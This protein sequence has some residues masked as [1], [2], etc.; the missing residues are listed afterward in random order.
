MKVVDQDLFYIQV[1]YPLYVKIYYTVWH[2]L[3]H[4]FTVFNYSVLQALT[5]CQRLLQAFTECQSLLQVFTVYHS[6]LHIYVYCVSEF[7]AGVYCVSE[8]S[9][10]VYCM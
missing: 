9:T 1:R 10:G 4:V 2:S 8:S 6:L 7:T 3:L 5:T